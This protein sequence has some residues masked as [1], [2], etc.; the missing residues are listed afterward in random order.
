MRRWLNLTRIATLQ[1]VV[2][3]VK[4]Q[5]HLEA[6]ERFLLIVTPVVEE[7]FVKAHHL[8]K[9]PTVEDV[10]FGYRI[11]PARGIAFHVPAPAN[12]H[13]VAPDVS[14]QHL[15]DERAGGLLV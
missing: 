3:A 6:V 14:V 4:G 15:L 12:A 10:G 1:S 11:D 5:R 13:P 7:S 2:Y 8:Q 9:M